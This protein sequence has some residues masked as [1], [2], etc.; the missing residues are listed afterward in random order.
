MRRYFSILFIT[1]LSLGS[2]E[3]VIDID[4]NT[5]EPALVARA[6]IIQD[7]TAKVKLTYTGSYFDTT[8]AGIE[9]AAMVSIDDNSGR[10]ETLEYTGEGVY[11]GNIIRG[12]ENSEYTLNISTGDRLY[13]G[14]SYL[15]SKPEILKLEYEKMD[16]PHYMERNIYSLTTVIT[17]DPGNDNYYMLR[18]YRN[19]EL[20]ND[21]YPIF[22]DRYL[23][24]DTIGYK[25]YRLDF[26]RTDTVRV[27]L[28]AIDN[29]VYNYFNLVNDVL[30][31]AM[32]SSTPFNPESNI[33]GGILGY[34][35]ASSFDS[36][37]II[38]H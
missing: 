8:G 32:S 30:F 34:F 15:N 29:G 28:Y 25:D 1:A 6:E 21:Y 14:R 7:S 20:M 3:E 4:L 11:R 31:S 36:D 18:F 13:S 5:S 24:A 19:G 22:S 37:S 12:K 23:E 16:I 35:M 33:S 26:Y 9:E 10:S 38:I 27:E 17:D 2:C